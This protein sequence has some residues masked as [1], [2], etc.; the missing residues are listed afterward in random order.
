MYRETLDTFIEEMRRYHTHIESS[1]NSL[2]ALTALTISKDLRPELCNV[3]ED[4]WLQ[5]IER[6]A[7]S[8]KSTCSSA[9][10]CAWDPPP[11][12][13]LRLLKGIPESSL[14]MALSDRQLPAECGMIFLESN[15]IIVQIHAFPLN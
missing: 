3:L 13:A 1:H 11:E 8:Q 14:E 7:S 12:E 2:V 6:Q 15:K 4:F 9:L 5:S 10:S